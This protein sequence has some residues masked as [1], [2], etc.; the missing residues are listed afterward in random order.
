MEKL[1]KIST[2]PFGF[3]SRTIR[4]I[5]ISI[6]IKDHQIYHNINFGADWIM[7]SAWKCH[8][9]TT[10]SQASRSQLTA[11]STSVILWQ[12]L[13]SYTTKMPVALDS[14][15]FNLFVY[16]LLWRSININYSFGAHFYRDL[17]T[18]LTGKWHT[19]NSRHNLPAPLTVCIQ[20]IPVI[21]H[22]FTHIRDLCQP[23]IRHYLLK[24]HMNWDPMGAAILDLKFIKCQAVQ[25]WFLHRLCICNVK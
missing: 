21:F 7:G 5:T 3:T 14:S 24:F 1:H 18:S 22:H 11:D 25:K 17:R 12:T 19:K 4:S 13:R 8:Y 10:K 16:Q 15:P 2:I 23:Q 9:S 20:L 6:Y